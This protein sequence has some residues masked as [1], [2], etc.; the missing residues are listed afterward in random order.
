[1]HASMY[2]C[3]TIQSENIRCIENIY[4]ITAYKASKNSQNAFFSEKQP[5]LEQRLLRPKAP[6]RTLS[7]TPFLGLTTYTC[8]YRDPQIKPS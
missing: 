3:Q 8:Q 7:P 1:M 6:P 5:C 4:K 2:Q